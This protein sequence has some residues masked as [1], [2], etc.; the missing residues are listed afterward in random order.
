MIK[1]I[2]NPRTGSEFAVFLSTPK[3][4]F[5][6]RSM[7][8]GAVTEHEGSIVPAMVMTFRV[9]VQP[10]EE[11]SVPN[12]GAA[13]S[14]QYDQIIWTTIAS[15]Y[16]S[17][18]GQFV[19]TG[20]PSATALKEALQKEQFFKQVYDFFAKNVP[21]AIPVLEHTEVE[22]YCLRELEAA[23][24][25]ENLP[26]PERFARTTLPSVSEKEQQEALEAAKSAGLH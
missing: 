23:I 11:G 19:L 16:A 9:R 20:K 10:Q 21:D 2:E 12:A 14:D 17:C 1:T 26:Q 13:I 15:G 4:V 5:A 25:E 7:L 3:Y 18:L 8:A 22:A 6:I 24:L